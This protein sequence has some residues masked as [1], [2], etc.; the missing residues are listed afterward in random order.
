MALGRKEKKKMQFAEEHI[1]NEVDTKELVYNMDD[2]RNAVRICLDFGKENNVEL[3]NPKGKA[4]VADMYRKYEAQNKVIRVVDERIEKR[5]APIERKQD[6]IMNFLQNMADK[7]ETPAETP[8]VE[9]RKEQRRRQ[10]Q[11]PQQNLAEQTT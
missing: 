9:P 8:V 7:K 10:I 6:Q 2:V 4:V 1:E 11:E 5:L 3:I